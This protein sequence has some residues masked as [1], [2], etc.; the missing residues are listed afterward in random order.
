MEETPTLQEEELLVEDIQLVCS[1]E[2][3]SAQDSQHQ[4]VLK[5]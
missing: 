4:L 5:G 3:S 1:E 2:Q